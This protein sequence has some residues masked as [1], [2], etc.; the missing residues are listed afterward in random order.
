MSDA[1]INFGRLGALDRLAWFEVRLSKTNRKLNSLATCTRTIRGPPRTMRGKLLFERAGTEGTA[2]SCCLT[3]E[4]TKT[5]TDEK[6]KT[7]LSNI[8]PRAVRRALL[9]RRGRPFPNPLSSLV[10][11]L[12]ITT[13]APPHPPLPARVRLR[14]FRVKSHDARRPGREDTRYTLGQAQP[15]PLSDAQL[16]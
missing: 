6:T 2:S 10:A 9:G 4:K 13:C 16:S 3:T 5:K 15:T 12:A 14:I 8:I 11:Q 1:H 7:R